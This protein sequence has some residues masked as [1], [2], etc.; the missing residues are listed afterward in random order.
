M[1]VEQRILSGL[2]PGEYEHPLDRR[3]LIALQKTPG[4]DKLTGKY[5]E[6]RVGRMI[7]MKHTG[8]AVQVTEG[9]LPKLYRVFADTCEILD[10]SDRPE[11]YLTWGYELNAAAAGATDPLVSLNSGCV[12]S[13]STG[14][15]MFLLGGALGHIKSDHILYEELTQVLPLVRRLAG[16]VPFGIGELVFGG[17]ELALLY[18]RR[19]SQYSADRAGL[20]ACQDT[21]A[22]DRVMIRMA[23]MPVSALGPETEESF[24]Q[25]AGQFRERDYGDLNTVAKD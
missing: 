23:G 2:R 9:N 22:A 4:L 14:E 12:D 20:L 7:R 21:G 6:Y 15:I 3:A 24:R 5:K 19:M 18:W 11:L 25:Q 13:L 1:S 17:V 16:A 8:S 10:F